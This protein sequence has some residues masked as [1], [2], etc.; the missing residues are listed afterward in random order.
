MGKIVLSFWENFESKPLHEKKK[1]MLRINAVFKMVF[2]VA[3]DSTFVKGP[4]GTW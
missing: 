4:R 1:I 2:C 3:C